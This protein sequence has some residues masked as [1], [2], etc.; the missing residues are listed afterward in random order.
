M[1]LFAEDNVAVSKTINFKVELFEPTESF[2]PAK[3]YKTRLKWDDLAGAEQ[4]K[5]LVTEPESVIAVILAEAKEEAP[6]PEA[7]KPARAAKRPQ[8]GRGGSRRM[9]GFRS[10]SFIRLHNALVGF[11]ARAFSHERG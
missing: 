5:L 2:K 8:R 1:H 11:P 3:P 10:W 6:R 4:S 7:P 9:V